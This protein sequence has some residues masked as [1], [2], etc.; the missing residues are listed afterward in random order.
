MYLWII[1][2]EENSNDHIRDC[3]HSVYLHLNTTWL[4]GNRWNSGCDILVFDDQ[5]KYTYRTSGIELLKKYSNQM[6]VLYFA[7]YFIIYEEKLK[8]QALTIKINRNYCPFCVIHSWEFEHLS[9]VYSS[10]DACKFRN[11]N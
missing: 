8:D 4:I 5:L 11:I 7:Y 1:L 10:L 3:L 6:K 9:D 2:Y